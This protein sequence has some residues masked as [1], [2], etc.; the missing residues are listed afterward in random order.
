MSTESQP[1]TE[2]KPNGSNGQ[3]KKEKKLVIAFLYNVRH[4]YP[5]P[6]DARSQ[7]ESDFDDPETIEH[8]IKHLQN[9]GYEVLPIEANEQAYLKLFENRKKIDMV[10]NFAEGIYGKD[11]EAQMPAMLEMLQLPYTGS[12]PLT[13]ALGL[14][15]AKAKE[16][17][18]QR[19]LP[20]LP[21]QLFRTGKERLKTE[22]KF[23][24][25]I[26]PVSQGSS[27]G[28]TNK[29]VVVDEKDLRK[30]VE[31]SIKNFN[32]MALVEPYLTGRE[33][34]VAM[35]GN[36]PK[37]L[38]IIESDHSVLPTDFTK[39]DSLEV[40]WYFEEQSKVEHLI[41][42]AKIDDQFRNKLEYI[43]YGVWN[44]LDVK[45]WCRIDIRCDE[46]NNPYVLE[47]NMPC[48]LLPPEVSTTSYFPLA[49][50]AAGIEYE[51]V[52]KM[53]IEAALKRYRA[54]NRLLH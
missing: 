41:C 22:L 19:K 9:C 11:R 21:D 6:N 30:Q 1:A 47:I 51:T 37:I 50:R 3:V 36:P 23:P 24:L 40:K 15:K 17:L 38:P 45:D 54:R 39:I 43:C 33:F 44:A 48:G 35:I 18:S 52:L 20:V 32:Q 29:S 26:K 16:I 46:E 31:M 4:I 14:H 8:M 13:H 5:D 27:A 7:L 12:S 49:A 28:I 42:P 53:I 25:I 2:T 34:S 10:F